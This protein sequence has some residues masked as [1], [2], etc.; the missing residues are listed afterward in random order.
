[1]A[2]RGLDRKKLTEVAAP[3]D[4]SLQAA[5]LLDG[6]HLKLGENLEEV[7]SAEKTIVIKLKELRNT[8]QSN[9][10][11]AV[12]QAEID[13]ILAV[14]RQLAVNAIADAAAKGSKADKIKRANNELLKGDQEA[15]LDHPDKAIDHY[16]N[17]WNNACDA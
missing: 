4:K 2:E 17:A 14:D 10:P 15:G 12:F 8:N 11:A 13:Q 7:F 16:K 1:M 6:L 5:P 3:L 9:A